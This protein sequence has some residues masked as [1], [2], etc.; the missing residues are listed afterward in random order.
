MPFLPDSKE[1]PSVLNI[2]ST[3]LTLNEALHEKSN[4][5]QVPLLILPWCATGLHS[6]VCC[7]AFFKCKSSRQTSFMHQ[8]LLCWP[9]KTVLIVIFLWGASS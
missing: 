1:M 3:V 5:L 7:N 6:I 4:M 2:E 9:T 8:V